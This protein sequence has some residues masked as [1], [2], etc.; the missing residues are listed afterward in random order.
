MEFKGKLN[1]DM[2]KANSYLS[3]QTISFGNKTVV[4]SALIILISLNFLTITGIEIEGI[5]VSINMVIITI[6]LQVV[7]FYYY[8]QFILSYDADKYTDIIGE[9]YHDFENELLSSY[10]LAEDK[11]KVLITEK[12]NIQNEFTA[13]GTTLERKK[14][15]LERLTELSSEL[16][17]YGEIIKRS[18]E[19]VTKEDTKIRN[20]ITIVKKYKILNF[21]V[22]QIIYFVGLAAVLLRFVFYMCQIFEA[23][24]DPWHYLWH[25]QLK[26]IKV[27]FESK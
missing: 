14:E 11:L 25:D 27:I 9:D 5:T 23:Q 20:F 4:T 19:A 10:K 13:V 3:E 24:D 18:K 16:N 12:E 6:V 1:L 26:Y 22:P 7:N 8:Q 21:K 17:E 2:K 15:L